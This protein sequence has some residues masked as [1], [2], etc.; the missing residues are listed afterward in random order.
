MEI[1]S[2]HLMGTVHVLG[3]I[4]C[5]WDYRTVPLFFPNH[6]INSSFPMTVRMR[7][8]YVQTMSSFLPCIGSC[9]VP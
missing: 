2:I 5:T 7:A 6:P 3:I 9:T 8:G 4:V 1:V